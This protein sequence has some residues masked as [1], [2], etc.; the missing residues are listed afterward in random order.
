MPKLN[1]LLE[2]PKCGRGGWRR[3]P[4]NF[5]R[6]SCPHR[7][8]AA[9]AAAEE[10]E[11]QAG[12]KRWENRLERCNPVR[13]QKQG[14]GL[15]VPS[16]PTSKVCG[17]FSL[18]YLVFCFSPHS[19]P[20]ACML[21]NADRAPFVFFFFSI[22]RRPAGGHPDTNSQLRWLVKIGP[23][24]PFGR[25]MISCENG[26]N[27]LSQELDDRQKKRGGLSLFFEGNILSSEIDSITRQGTTVLHRCG[28]DA[29]SSVNPRLLQFRMSCVRINGGGIVPLREF[30]PPRRTVLASYCSSRLLM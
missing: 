3:R 17:C 6:P 2:N 28:K 15:N 8:R 22:Y 18:F 26:W 25:S 30:V 1:A 14:L 10:E 13:P 16:T 20:P 27:C 11:G 21:D 7:R 23:R 29:Q 9:A 19:S 12:E 24:L 4:I 5:L